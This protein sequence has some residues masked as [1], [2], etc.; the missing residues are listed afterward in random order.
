MA[1]ARSDGGLSIRVV[2]G[3]VA[4]SNDQGTVL[5]EPGEV[6]SASAGQLPARTPSLYS[7]KAIQW[8]LYY[9]AILDCD[10]LALT[11][12]VRAELSLSLASYRTG[13]LVSALAQY[14][15]GRSPQ[16]AEERVY[17]AA[18]ELAIGRVDESELVLEPFL[19]QTSPVATTE[20][21]VG[22]L[23]LMQAATRFESRPDSS[24]SSPRLASE[25]LAES[26]FLQSQGELRAA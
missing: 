26:Y 19:L 16:S 12:V 20:R 25:W 24:T 1:E 7:S 22:A 4:L 11:E 21:L 18:L 14:P 13:D 3:S 10:E 15:L 2:E 6:G 23:R 5:L 8:C 17:L 9:P